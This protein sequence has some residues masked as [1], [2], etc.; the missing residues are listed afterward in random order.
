MVQTMLFFGSFFS[1]V[2][3]GRLGIVTGAFWRNATEATGKVPGIT[4]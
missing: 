1:G 2:D 4:V 3:L